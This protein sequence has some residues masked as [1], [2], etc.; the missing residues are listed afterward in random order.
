MLDREQ[1]EATAVDILTRFGLADLSMRRLARELDVQVGALYWH[2]KNKQELLVG[3]ATRLL[4]GIAIPPA[5]IDRDSACEA[6]GELARG[7]RASLVNVPD[8]AEVV[9][10]AQSL[11]S[12]ALAPLNRLRTSFEAAGVENAAWA[13]HL[14]MNHVLG[15][16]AVAQESVRL[17]AVDPGVA[18]SPHGDDAFEWGL[19]VILHGLFGPTAPGAC[20]HQG[21]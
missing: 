11:Q 17:A 13:Q 3:V 9:Q 6:V 2:V 10:V 7:I 1:V 14:V 16:I 4:D 20:P 5:P 19:L 8:S 21:P 12:D 15:S 18:G